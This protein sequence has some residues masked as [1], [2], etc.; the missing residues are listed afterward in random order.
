MRNLSA[1]GT[2][3]VAHRPNQPKKSTTSRRYDTVHLIRV[4]TGI[5]LACIG[6]PSAYLVSTHGPYSLL[7]TM[8]RQY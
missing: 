6:L 1:T 3:R 7:K 4:A 5:A 2:A 8:I